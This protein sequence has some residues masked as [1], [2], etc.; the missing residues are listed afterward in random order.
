MQNVEIKRTKD[1]LVIEID[2]TKS[3]GPSKSGKTIIIASTSGNASIPG[4]N[5]E[6]IKVGL[7]VFK[8]NPTNGQES[9]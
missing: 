5:K 4:E 6:G 9:E 8:P 7:N 2:L 1:R 3:Y